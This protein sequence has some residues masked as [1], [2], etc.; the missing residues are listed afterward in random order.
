M[1]KKYNVTTTENFEEQFKNIIYYI[2]RILK[3]KEI[4]KKFYIKVK[5]SIESLEYN[6]E[7]FQKIDQNSNIRKMVIK[8]FIILYIVNNNSKQ[9]SILHI[10][11]R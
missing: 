1:N 10:F 9:V 2:S 7:R 6:P 11:N 4:A 8:N 3:E 5:K